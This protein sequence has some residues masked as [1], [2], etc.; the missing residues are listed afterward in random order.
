MRSARRA[1]ALP[2][3]QR[4]APTRAGGRHAQPAAPAAATPAMRG[5]RPASAAAATQQAVDATA[6]RPRPPR[7][8]ATAAR[9][10]ASACSAGDAKRRD[11]GSCRICRRGAAD[12]PSACAS[13][14]RRR[15]GA[16]ERMR[17][18]AV[19]GGWWPRVVADG[20]QAMGGERPVLTSLSLANAHRENRLIE[21][22]NAGW[23]GRHGGEAQRL[24]WGGW[25]P[26]RVEDNGAIGAEGLRR[27]LESRTVQAHLCKCA[28]SAFKGRS[29]R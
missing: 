24:G 23:E 20:G 11:E 4:R 8:A 17:W 7:R 25:G 10:P 9:T 18:V 27:E 29:E 21:R 19:D 3:P 6:R 5:V 12:P 26:H 22:R 13:L 1:A 28:A 2:A 14:R 16:A 15:T